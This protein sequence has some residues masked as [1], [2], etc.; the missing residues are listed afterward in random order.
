MDK[1][2]IGIYE[3]MTKDRDGKLI[4]NRVFVGSDGLPTHIKE[5]PVASIAD[6]PEAETILMVHK[7]HFISNKI[8]SNA[9]HPDRYEIREQGGK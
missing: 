4:P 2:L 1:V 6:G 9:R 3:E 7:Q 8:L 5:E